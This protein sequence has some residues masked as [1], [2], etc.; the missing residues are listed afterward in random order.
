V[1]ILLKIGGAFEKG[2][3][4]IESVFT[5]IVVGLLLMMMLLGT[6]DVVGRYVFNSPIKGTLEISELLMAVAIFLGWGYVQSSK[7]NIRVDFII[8]RYPLKANQI[9]ELVILIL[10]FM[11]FAMITWQ[12][13]NL[14][15]I[16]LDYG[17]LIENVYIPAFPFKLMVAVGAIMV[18]LESII[19]IVYQLHDMT[20]KGEAM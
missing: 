13:F 7:S 1:C 4:K 5:Y 17:R 3:Q 19:Q 14:A 8:K 2:I 16:D 20:K 9:V 10:T 15:M 12:S 18:C 6:A 11:L